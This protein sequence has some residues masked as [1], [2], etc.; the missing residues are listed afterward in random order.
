VD[1]DAQYRALVTPG[2]SNALRTGFGLLAARGK[3]LY[4]SRYM[5]AAT[6]RALAGCAA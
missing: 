1:L 5:Q 2:F 3:A 4:M 6:Y